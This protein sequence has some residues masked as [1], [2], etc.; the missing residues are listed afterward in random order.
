MRQ[1]VPQDV[2]I[3][4]VVEDEEPAG[5]VGEPAFDGIDGTLLLLFVLFGEVQEVCEGDEVGGERFTRFGSDPEDGIVVV[6]VT[7]SVF[8]GGLGLADATEAADG[9]RQGGGFA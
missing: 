7:V 9:L 4:G 1:E 8:Y 6:L 3:V 2:E 5:G